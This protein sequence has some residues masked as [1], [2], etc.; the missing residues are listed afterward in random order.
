[1]VRAHVDQFERRPEPLGR[2]DQQTRAVAN[3][4][5]PGGCGGTRLERAD[6][7]GIDFHQDDARVVR[8]LARLIEHEE[9]GTVGRP[10]QYIRHEGQRA[11]RVLGVRG[12]VDD[13]QAHVADGVVE[14]I[15]AGSDGR[16]VIAVTAHRVEP[17][18]SG[19]G[20][21]DAR[22]ATFEW[23]AHDD[24]RADRPGWRRRCL[25]AD[26]AVRPMSGDRR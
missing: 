22:L 16:H 6:F 13:A 9:M 18:V 8:V 15:R 20:A 2:E 4:G 10:L 24:A 23:N 3:P 14:P 11:D 25:P 17:D 7:A 19:G 12:D 26:P 21:N 1:M 5:R